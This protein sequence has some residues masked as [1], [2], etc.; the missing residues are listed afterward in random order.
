MKQLLTSSAPHFAPPSLPSSETTP[1][2]LTPVA[3]AA[4][5]S[6]MVAGIVVLEV[7]LAKPRQLKQGTM[8]ELFTGKTR[9][10]PPQGP[11][12]EFRRSQP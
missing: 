1:S 8:Q 11:P 6:D 12:H 7:T 2:A 10:V 5:L 9:L 4:I 3:V